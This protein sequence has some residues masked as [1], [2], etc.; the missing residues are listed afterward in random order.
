MSSNGTSTSCCRSLDRHENVYV[1]YVSRQP[2]E[3]V[4][5]LG[6]GGAHPC[7]TAPPGLSLVAGRLPPDGRRLRLN[8]EPARGAP[9]TDLGD[10]R[11]CWSAWRRMNVQTFLSRSRR[12]LTSPRNASAP[13]LIRNRRSIRTTIRRDGALT[14]NERGLVLTHFEHGYGDLRTKSPRHYW[15]T[16]ALTIYDVRTIVISAS[17]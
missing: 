14:A 7:R 5:S 6:V 9:A 13:L 17:D 11:C 16:P 10:W 1:R 3:A 12:R 4:V 15:R 8:A 2:V